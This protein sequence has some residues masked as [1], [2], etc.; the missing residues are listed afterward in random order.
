[1]VLGDETWAITARTPLYGR[2][3]AGARV[4]QYVPHGH[5]ERLRVTAG[6][7]RSG[8]CAAWVFEGS[9]TAEAWASFTA[10]SVGPALRPGDVVIRD[11]LCGHQHADVLDA[12]GQRGVQVNL[13]PPYSPDF[14][15]IAEAF[16][17]V[18]QALG[19]SRARTTTQRIEAVGV[20]L[21]AITGEDIRGWF[22]H[23]GY[24]T[25]S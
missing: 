4:V 7:R 25:D 1:L 6:L 22:E 24:H 10:P 2:A 21:Q 20:A 5:G 15:P 11:N 19:R 18:N 8:V 17:K 13:L 3:P 12:L 9:A 16:S 14:N 23:C